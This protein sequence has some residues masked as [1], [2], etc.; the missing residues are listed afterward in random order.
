MYIYL[1]IEVVPTRACRDREVVVPVVTSLFIQFMASWAKSSRRKVAL[2]MITVAISLLAY[3]CQRPAPD[4][5]TTGYVSPTGK[6]AS[7]Q[8]GEESGKPDQGEIS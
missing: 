4:V 3:M 1:Q 7:G 8:T 6:R 2:I 5:C